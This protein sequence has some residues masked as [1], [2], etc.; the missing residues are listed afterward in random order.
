ME[1]KCIQKIY[2]M[3]LTYM[4]WKAFGLQFYA[5]IERK[6]M[7]RHKKHIHIQT[8]TQIQHTFIT[9]ALMHC[10]QYTYIHLTVVISPK[11]GNYKFFIE[12]N[13]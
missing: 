3:T 8:R 12:V 4:H 10:I 11:A 6:L 13:C 2:R 7:A 9:H 1:F 5:I